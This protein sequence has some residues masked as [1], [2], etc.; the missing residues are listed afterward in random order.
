[1]KQTLIL[2][3]SQIST[4]GECPTLWKLTYQESLEPS[5]GEAKDAIAMGT[6]GH[7]WLEMFYFNRSQGISISD[8]V[9]FANTLDPDAIDEADNHQYPLE[10]DKR[11]KVLKRLQEY[12]MTYSSNDYAPDY[13]C[14]Y[15][16]QIDAAGLPIDS[17][18]KIPLIEQGF[19]YK[20]YEDKQF[21]FIIEGRIDF[22]GTHSGHQFFM[23]HK[24]QLRERKLYPKS[25]QFKNYALATGLQ[26]GIINYIR[27]HETVTPKTFQREPISFGGNELRQWAIELIEDYYFPIAKSVRENKFRKERS[28][29]P[30][31][32]G[33]Q[34]QFTPLC[35]ESPQVAELIKIQ[36][37]K[38][39]T[40]WT[41][42]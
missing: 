7:K 41:P 33:Y 27:L 14:T 32:F 24:F 28:A 3:S 31:K 13:K 39:K 30:G 17:T 16:V 2:D 23:D 19:S 29:C 42:W 1:M 12:W 18:K 36:N 22:I 34:C 26:M 9:K 38:K 15:D 10:L 21:L 6:L 40:P 20:L 25:I 11:K 8:S 4:Y 5:I 37:F 35:E